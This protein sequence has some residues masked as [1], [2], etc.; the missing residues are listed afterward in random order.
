[1]MSDASFTAFII[2]LI[3]GGIYGYGFPKW[4]AAQVKNKEVKK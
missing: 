3:V 1:M 4:W 2:G